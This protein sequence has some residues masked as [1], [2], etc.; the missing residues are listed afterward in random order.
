MLVTTIDRMKQLVPVIVGNEFGKYE[1]FVNEAREWL[2][3]EITGKA[4]Y[5]VLEAEENIILL[6]YCESVVANKAYLSGLPFFDLIETEAGFA[7]TRTDT[8]APASPERVKALKAGVEVWLSDAIERLLE[9]LEQNS[10]YHEAWKSSAAYSMLT[11]TYIHTLREFR[12]YAPFEGN[13]MDFIKALPAMLDVIHLKIEPVISPDLSDEI[14]EELR[15]DDLT[16]S[17]KE[18]LKNIRFAYANFVVG[19]ENTALS[20]IAKVR[21]TLLASPSTYP[22][23]ENSDLY[24][25]ILATTIEKN[26][27]EKPIFRAGF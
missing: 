4:L 27:I 17:N 7:V 15:D 3:S 9:Y 24:A 22:A 25:Q 21:K 5:D 6:Q 8:K 13:R 11:E 19:N 18:I 10:A 16:E 14:I 20:Y 23:F 26:T 2:K 1:T 12:R